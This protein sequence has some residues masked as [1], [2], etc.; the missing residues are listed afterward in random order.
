MLLICEEGEKSAAMQLAQALLVGDAEPELIVIERSNLLELDIALAAQTRRSVIVPCVAPIIEKKVRERTSQALV[1]G[2]LYADISW[3]SSSPRRPLPAIRKL[4]TRLADSAP[5]PLTSAP[6]SGE[7]SGIAPSPSSALAGAHEKKGAT[8]QMAFAPSQPLQ[9]LPPLT[10]IAKATTG[11]KSPPV[12]GHDS[13]VDFP[14]VPSATAAAPEAPTSHAPAAAP[15]VVPPRSAGPTVSKAAPAT[16]SVDVDGLFSTTSSDS[17]S[18]ASAVAQRPVGAMDSSSGVIAGAAAFM[19]TQRPG[20]VVGVII[21]GL[22]VGIG[23]IGDRRS[24]ERAVL[25]AKAEE[26][27]F[28]AKVAKGPAPTR[29]A[30]AGEVQNTPAVP[31]EAAPADRQ[32]VNDAPDVKAAAA[33]AREPEVPSEAAVEVAVASAKGVSPKDA[34]PPVNANESAAVEDAEGAKP[35]VHAG[36]KASGVAV[37]VGDLY[38]LS[39]PEGLSPTRWLKAAL[40]CK[41]L[42]AEGSDLWRLPARRDF[43]RLV[44]MRPFPAPRLWTSTK[45]SSDGKKA[46]LYQRSRGF[47]AKL[48]KHRRAEF[49]CVRD[50]QIP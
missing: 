49:V 42:V 33:V 35:E 45:A 43:R 34:T 30:T 14:V 46:F 18:E 19:R 44:E 47:F 5:T 24:G 21:G 36:A 50:A 9:P 25:A 27:A 10:G 16:A 3:S 32:P 38:V 13:G 23:G 12:M 11:A 15:P 2:H 20:L 22:I 41:D 31:A 28:A 1:D 7:D 4:V 26:P 6:S 39:A 40:Y 29:S 17:D 37:R 8:I 48:E